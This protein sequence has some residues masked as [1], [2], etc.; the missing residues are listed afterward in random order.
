MTLSDL[1]S[2]AYDFILTVYSNHGLSR[3]VSEIKA[4]LVE[5]I[6][7]PKTKL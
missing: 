7:L 2:G 3:T 4:I 6:L 5:S 1:W